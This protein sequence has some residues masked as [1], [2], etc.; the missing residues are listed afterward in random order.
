M[1]GLQIV[2]SPNRSTQEWPPTWCTKGSSITPFPGKGVPSACMRA[3]RAGLILTPH[4]TAERRGPTSHGRQETRPLVWLPILGLFSAGSHGGAAAR[5][6][7]RS[8]EKQKAEPNRKDRG[9]DWISHSLSSS[10]DKW[11]NSSAGL[12]NSR[13]VCVIKWYL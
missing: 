5:L 10:K 3:S 6:L 7:A 11:G 13:V 4:R 9:R 8:T 1:R 2:C 12:N